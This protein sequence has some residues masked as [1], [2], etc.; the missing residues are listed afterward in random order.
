MY[1]SH[2]R[3]RVSVAVL[4]L[5]FAGA[6]CATPRRHEEPLG[7]AGLP[8]A[9]VIAPAAAQASVPPRAS[10]SSRVPTILVIGD[11]HTYGAF[12]QRLHERLAAIGG[13]AVISEAAGG[14][15][16]E[17]YLEER[18]EALV[19]YRVRESARDERVPRALV[20]RLRSPMDSL[21]VLLARHEPEIVV[22]AL[23]TNRPR[24]P[25]GESCDTFMQRLVHDAPARHVFWIGPAAIGRDRSAAVVASLRACVEKIAGATFIDSTTFNASSPLPPDNPHFGPADA[26]RW[27]DTAFEQIGPRILAE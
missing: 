7:A 17:T 13:H 23:G 3:S 14:A 2:M 25:V 19:G 15:T 8:D 26:R 6:A 9:A 5:A 24:A 11:S 16:T 10:R 21:D 22:V 12:G 27:A 1:T 4:S 20:D 18:P